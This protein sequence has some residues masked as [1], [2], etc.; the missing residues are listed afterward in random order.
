METTM[1]LGNS[2][3]LQKIDGLRELGISDYIP[4]PQVHANSSPEFRAD[5]TIACCG[6]RS[7]EVKLLHALCIQY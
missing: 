2:V 1:N 7:V 3:Q 5:I 4:L 6:W